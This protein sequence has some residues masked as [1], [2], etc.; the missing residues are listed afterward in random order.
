MAELMSRCTSKRDP[1][2]YLRETFNVVW[3]CCYWSATT[4][5]DDPSAARIVFVDTAKVLC[6]VKII[7]HHVWCVRGG[8]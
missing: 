1:A 3:S 4:C 8:H 2:E 6:D 7:Y 5:A